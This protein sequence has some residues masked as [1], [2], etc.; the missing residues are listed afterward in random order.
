[1]TAR[2]WDR[3]PIAYWDHFLDDR[4]PHLFSVDLEGGEPHA[5]TR[6]SG[7]A[8]SKPDIDAFT[9]DI[10]PEVSKSPSSRTSTRPAW[11]RTST[12]SRSRPAAAS[13]RGT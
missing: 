10:S 5:I 7:F 3:A 4:E 2:V 9:Y 1:M 13:R 6:L 12:S 8:L 11:T